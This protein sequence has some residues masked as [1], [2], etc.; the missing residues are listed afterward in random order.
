MRIVDIKFLDLNKQYITDKVFKDK[1]CRLLVFRFIQV[2]I[3][4]MNYIKRKVFIIYLKEK[5]IC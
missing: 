1:F 2:F 5:L 4:S 3:H